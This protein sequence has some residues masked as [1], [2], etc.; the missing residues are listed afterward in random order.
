MILENKLLNYDEDISHYGYTK[1]FEMY[2]EGS[3]SDRK[4]IYNNLLSGIGQPNRAFIS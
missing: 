1:L 4:Y 3:H 2:L